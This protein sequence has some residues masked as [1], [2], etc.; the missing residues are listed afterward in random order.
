MYHHSVPVAVELL[1]V[2]LHHFMC[3]V[4]SWLCRLREQLQQAGARHEQQQ[5]AAAKAVA[6][7]CERHVGQERALQQ[8]VQKLQSDL[9]VAQ[10]ITEGKTILCNSRPGLHLFFITLNRQP[11]TVAE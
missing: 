7:E 1:S 3:L 11:N 2:K 4:S 10:V 6:E 9:A 8:Q 5:A